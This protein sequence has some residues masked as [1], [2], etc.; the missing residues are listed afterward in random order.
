MDPVDCAVEQ[1]VVQPSRESSP[2]GSS[3]SG[4]ILY[5]KTAVPRN[6]AKDMKSK[7]DHGIGCSKK[8]LHAVNTPNSNT[9]T[10]LT[11]IAESSSFIRLITNR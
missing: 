7:T 8:M 10:E 2:L 3:G 5:V 4:S 9:A 6:A 11:M 1:T